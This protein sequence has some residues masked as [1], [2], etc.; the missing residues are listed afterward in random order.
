MEQII[1]KIIEVGKYYPIYIEECKKEILEFD[2]QLIR[3]STSY[4]QNCSSL[5]MAKEIKQKQNIPI[6]FGGANCEGI[7][8]TRC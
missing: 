5:L 4:Y 2:P 7:M 8:G 1:D 3:F 6:V